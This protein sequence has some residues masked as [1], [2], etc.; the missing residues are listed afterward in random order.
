MTR[1]QSNAHAQG[2]THLSQAY[3]PFF[4]VH[5]ISSLRL[6]HRLNLEKAI[7]EELRISTDRNKIFFVVL[8][9][10]KFGSR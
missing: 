9:S 7:I 10:E 4:Q 5:R 2:I 3:L 6:L 8:T 1:K